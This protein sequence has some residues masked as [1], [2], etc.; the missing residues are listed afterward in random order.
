LHVQILNQVQDDTSL[1]HL[2]KPFCQLNTLDLTLNNAV[3]MTV[4]NTAIKIK[5]A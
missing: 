4:Q 1:Y 5:P 2:I 3:M